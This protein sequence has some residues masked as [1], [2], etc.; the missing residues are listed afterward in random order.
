MPSVSDLNPERLWAF[1][2][3]GAESVPVTASWADASGA[4]FSS[5]STAALGTPG[6]SRAGQDCR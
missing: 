4:S 2:G 6:E 3:L 1:L 5:K